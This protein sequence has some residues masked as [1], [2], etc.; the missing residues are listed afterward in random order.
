MLFP[1]LITILGLAYILSPL[2]FIPD[3]IPILGWSDDAFVLI[4]VG[5]V[6]LFYIGSVIISAILP[7]IVIGLLIIGL[8]SFLNV[9][10]KKPKRRK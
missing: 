10:N 2:D 9:L 1:I 8:I 4:I 6:W 3:F 7:I 5:V